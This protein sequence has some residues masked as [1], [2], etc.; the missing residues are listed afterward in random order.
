M[1]WR[2]VLFLFSYNQ[3]QKYYI[4]IGFKCVY[5]FKY[6]D[7]R[8]KNWTFLVPTVWKH[9]SFTTAF[10]IWALQLAREVHFSGQHSLYISSNSYICNDSYF[11]NSTVTSFDI[12]TYRSGNLMKYKQEQNVDSLKHNALTCNK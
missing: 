6:Y 8:S 10:N 1:V 5:N 2:Y 7:G 11:M 4:H 9:H 12:F 3:T